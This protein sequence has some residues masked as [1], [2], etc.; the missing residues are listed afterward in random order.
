MVLKEEVWEWKKVPHNSVSELIL[1]NV[2]SNDLDIKICEGPIQSAPDT[3]LG[4]TSVKTKLSKELENEK[5]T[6]VLLVSF[7]RM[8]PGREKDEEQG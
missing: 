5:K 1:N 6:G 2:F 7:R 8:K 4:S 3:K